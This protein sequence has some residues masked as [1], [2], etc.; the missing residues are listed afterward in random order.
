MSNVASKAGESALSKFWNHPAGPKTIFF[1]A[2]TAKWGL[3]I[4]GLKDINRPVE[5]LSVSQ[6]VSLTAT[7]LIWTRYATVIN[8]VNYNLMS[9]NL[10]V[11][12]TGLYQMY[13]IWE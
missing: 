1:W 6:Q 11:G 8:P 3:V 13:R 9:V 5:K 10:F 4:A 2:P 7:G 12:A